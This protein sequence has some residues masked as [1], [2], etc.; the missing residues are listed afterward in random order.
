MIRY[1]RR[2]VYCSQDA[3]T[4]LGPRS[5]KCRDGLEKVSEDGPYAEFGECVTELILGGAFVDDELLV[6]QSAAQPGAANGQGFNLL[7]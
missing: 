6:A 3:G 4:P 7:S 1:S 5:H 2:V